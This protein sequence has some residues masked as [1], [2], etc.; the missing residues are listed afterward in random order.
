M[1]KGRSVYRLKAEG[2]AKERKKERAVSGVYI[3]YTR[4]A[5]LLNELIDVGDQKTSVG[6]KRVEWRG[7]ER[8]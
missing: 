8:G 2:I 5:F 7:T 4:Q 6:R 3:L 1:W